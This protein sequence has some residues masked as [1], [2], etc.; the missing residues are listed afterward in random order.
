MHGRDAMMMMMIHEK[1]RYAYIKRKDQ[2]MI[3]SKIKTA[4][5][6]AELTKFQLVPYDRIYRNLKLCTEDF[7]STNIEIICSYLEVSGS[8]LFRNPETHVRTRN[9]LEILG[10]MKTIKNL[11]QRQVNCSSEKESSCEQSWPGH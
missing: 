5:Y 6:L 9:V 11:D 2:L 8:F 1:N 7:S 10:R 4:R 3:E